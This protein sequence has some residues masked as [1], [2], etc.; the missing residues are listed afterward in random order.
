[1]SEINDRADYVRGVPLSKPNNNELISR[2]VNSSER[3]AY[4]KRLGPEDLH[5]VQ[6]VIHIVD[7]LAQFSFTPGV[8]KHQPKRTLADL[9][10]WAYS[11]DGGES[12]ETSEM[13]DMLIIREVN[14]P[15]IVGKPFFAAYAIGGYVTK[16]GE[17]PDI[18]LMVVTNTG[19]PVSLNDFERYDSRVRILDLNLALSFEGSDI[20]G[21]DDLPDN[22]NIGHTKGKGI[23]RIKPNDGSKPMD[24]VFVTSMT[25]SPGSPANPTMINPFTNEMYDHE[26]FSTREEF[27]TRLDVDKDGQPL[28]RT[29]LYCATQKTTRPHFRMR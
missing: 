4:L 28:P 5:N 12:V 20:E 14:N 19:F 21:L 25:M 1:M 26:I 27:E 29:L 24:I 11:R 17:R 13:S 15:P 3:A 6:K 9:N 8:V 2:R 22:Y 23:I 18:D 16:E 10:A 7:Q